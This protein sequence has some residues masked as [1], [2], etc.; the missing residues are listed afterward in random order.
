MLI[1]KPGVPFA[2]T[3]DIG[4]EITV[5][6]IAKKV[7]QNQP[8]FRYAGK[9]LTTEE[10]VVDNKKFPGAKFTVVTGKRRLGIAGTFL[11][12]TGE[13]FFYEAIPDPPFLHLLGSVEADDPMLGVLIEGA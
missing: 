5:V 4:S 9:P 11:I 10:I 7:G 3:A 8:V 6:S 1:P 12:D 13:Y 2:F